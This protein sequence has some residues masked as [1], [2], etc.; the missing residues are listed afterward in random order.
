MTWNMQLFPNYG[1]LTRTRAINVWSGPQHMGFEALYK[2]QW[3]RRGFGT[4]NTRRLGI[5]CL[6][7]IRTQWPG[8]KWNYQPPPPTY[9]HIEKL[10]RKENGADVREKQRCH[11]QATR[12]QGRALD[13]RA[14][15]HSLRAVGSAQSHPS[16]LATTQRRTGRTPWR[17][18]RLLKL[19]FRVCLASPL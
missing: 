19:C 3:S 10:V 2:R 12:G 17:G 4:D 15:D 16:Y 11:E 1:R 7:P 14:S 18:L 6:E 9:R 5:W 13:L 8:A